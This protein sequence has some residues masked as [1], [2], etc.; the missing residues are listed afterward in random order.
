M[1][2][3][4]QLGTYSAIGMLNTGVHLAV[5]VLLF[6]VLG[7]QMLVA[8]AIG[9]CAGVA[10]SYFM[11]RRWTF[12]MRRA[13]NASE[14][15]KFVMVNLSALLLNVVTLQFLAETIGLP[16]EL[17]QIGAIA[18]SLAVNFAGNKWWTFHR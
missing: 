8:S 10:N 18:A 4:R 1:N 17:A 5:F 14:F 2:L 7:I 3:A 15:A 11:N 6:R 12:R 13:G 16:A 9:Y